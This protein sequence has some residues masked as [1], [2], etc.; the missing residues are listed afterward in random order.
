MPD[1]KQHLRAFDHR[2]HAVLHGPDR[3]DAP[4]FRAERGQPRAE[5]HPAAVVEDLLAEILHDPH[6]NVG[7]D[8]RLCVKQDLRA[9]AGLAEL[10]QHPAD[11]LVF[12]AGVELSVRKRTGA[13]LSELDV[14]LR[15]KRAARP[16]RLHLFLPPL[17]VQTAFE[18]DGA[19]PRHRQH[20]RGKHARGPEAHDHRPCLR[21]LRRL[22]RRI[23]H[24][25]RRRGLGAVRHF[26]DLVLASLHQHIDGV[27]E[28][29]IVFLPRIDRAFSD[30]QTLDLRIPDAKLPRRGADKLRAA[31]SGCKGNV[32][33]SYH[34]GFS[35]D[36]SAPSRPASQPEDHAH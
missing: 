28:P 27:N 6:Q 11:A 1:G 3:C 33:D 23:K 17:R 31:V 5:A 26:Q 24:V 16:E 22:R 19:K 12:R 36:P 34:T 2:L 7:A 29:H 20:Q 21:E 15:V 25:L 9:G 13:A 14:A 8:V 4:V 32:S 18:H 10:L 30:V 35:C